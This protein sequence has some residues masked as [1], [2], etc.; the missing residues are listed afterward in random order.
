MNPGC[1]P[2]DP[3]LAGEGGANSSERTCYPLLYID[4]SDSCTVGEN[5]QN[6]SYSLEDVSSVFQGASNSSTPFYI[7]SIV[8]DVT[9]ERSEKTHFLDSAALLVIMFLLFLTVI[10]IWVF[11]VR[12][13]R[14]LHETGLA[15]LYGKLIFR[16]SIFG[17]G[18]SPGV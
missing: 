2:S 17:R 3:V 6:G 14:I 1:L 13:F 8:Q 7:P 5:L 18:Q 16:V 10:T 12:R 4:P 11:K 9:D 15:V